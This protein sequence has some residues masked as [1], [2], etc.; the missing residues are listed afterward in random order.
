M[1]NTG[2]TQLEGNKLVIFCG[3][4]WTRTI[5]DFTQLLLDIEVSPPTSAFLCEILLYQ[6]YFQCLYRTRTY[7]DFLHNQPMTSYYLSGVESILP[8]LQ[9][10]QSNVSTNCTNKHFEVIYGI[11]TRVTCHETSVISAIRI[12]QTTFMSCKI[13]SIVSQVLD[14][15]PH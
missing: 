1:S 12:D 11:R 15:S 6:Q 10:F 3:N 13:T 9:T 2:N 14:Y 5:I 7:I 4:R 8:Q